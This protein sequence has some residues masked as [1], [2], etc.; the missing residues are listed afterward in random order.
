MTTTGPPRRPAG[1]RR[2]EPRLA[3]MV[4]QVELAIRADMDA[5]ARSTASPRSST[6]PSPCCS[7]SR[8][9]RGPSSVALLRL[10]QAGSEMVAHLE[11]KGLIAREPDPDNR[12][13][14][15]ISLTEE[16]ERTVRDCD[17]WMDRIEARLLA[18]LRCADRGLA[19]DPGRL[20]AHL[21]GSRAGTPP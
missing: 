20:R 10:P 3:Y 17:A 4:K 9:C 8:A 12:L 1:H 19:H 21:R 13:V 7:A 2:G 5:H 11:R 15:R 14:L 16:G 6:P 18:G